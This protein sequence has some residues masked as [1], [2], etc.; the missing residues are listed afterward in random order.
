MSFFFI[1]PGL[2]PTEALW[3]APP[4][5]ETLLEFLS[6]NIFI[7]C[8]WNEFNNIFLLKKRQLT[9]L[10]YLSGNL[11]MKSWVFAS[12]TTFTTSS[13]EAPSFQNNIFWD[14]CKEDWFLIDQTHLWALPFELEPI[15]LVSIQ[16]NLS[17]VGVIK[18]LN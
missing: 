9:W 18:S 12:L 6:I 14:C 13:I 4:L 2:Q 17:L 1:L 16:E 11:V 5:S 3:K 15:Y 8:F 10:S 7:K